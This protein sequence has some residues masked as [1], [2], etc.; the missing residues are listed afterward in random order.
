MSQETDVQFCQLGLFIYDGQLTSNVSASMSCLIC[1]SLSW[2][3]NVQ[4]F[5]LNWLDLAVSWVSWVDWK[6]PRVG[7]NVSK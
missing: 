5:H 6:Y 4:A 1:S 3:K 2:N 7:L